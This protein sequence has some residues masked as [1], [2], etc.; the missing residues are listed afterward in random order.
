[1]A[2]ALGVAPHT[3]LDLSASVNPLAPDVAALVRRVDDGCIRT[4]PDESAATAAMAGAL[5]VDTDRLVLTNGGSE[6]IAIVAAEHPRGV[7]V[8]PA[9][10][11]YRRHLADA[12]G[13]GGMRWRA[14]PS[15]PLGVLAEP[16][17]EAEVWDEAFWPLATGTWTRGDGGAFRL[18]SLTKVWGCPGLRLGYAVAP[19]AMAADAL[20]RR[21]PAW[22]VSGP[23]LAVVPELLAA[24]DLPAWRDGIASLRSSLASVWRDHGYDVQEAAGPWVLVD[25][26][27]P[28]RAPLARGG[29]LV[30][31]CASFGLAGVARVGVPD[32]AGL[33]RLGDALTAIRSAR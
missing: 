3:I 2:R 32:E 27:A 12:D 16:G 29:V 33:A 31:D 19:D 18:G 28:L 8:E 23:A 7:V 1:V 22:S 6:A 20:R 5:E 15:S 25:G 13:P 4:Y 26:A 17:D 9:F 11:L 30:R 21:R 24:T 10:S 14:N